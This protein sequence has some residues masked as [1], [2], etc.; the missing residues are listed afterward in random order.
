MTVEA[1]KNLE[2]R[3]VMKVLATIFYFELSH[4]DSYVPLFDIIPGSKVHMWKGSVHTVTPL[5]SDGVACV[6]LHEDFGK[7]PH[8]K[9]LRQTGRLN[10]LSKQLHRAL[11]KFEEVYEGKSGSI[12]LYDRKSYLIPPGYPLYRICPNF[13]EESQLCTYD[14]ADRT[15]SVNTVGL[16]RSSKPNAF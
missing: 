16:S 4:E 13:N 8:H 15:F 10:N 12:K 6:D 5:R 7:S 3:D 11:V 1:P 9:V 2:W 14:L